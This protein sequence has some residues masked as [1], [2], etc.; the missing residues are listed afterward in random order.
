MNRMNTDGPNGPDFY[1]KETTDLNRHGEATVP[2]R[3]LCSLS[4]VTIVGAASQ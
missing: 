2:E 1:T 3:Y 4:G